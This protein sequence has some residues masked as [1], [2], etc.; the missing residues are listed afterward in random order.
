MAAMRLIRSGGRPFPFDC[1]WKARLKLWCW[2]RKG[3]RGIGTLR[4]EIAADAIPRFRFVVCL[5]TSPPIP[6]PLFAA[7]ANEGLY[8]SP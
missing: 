2:V 3:K 8:E 1:K 6:R 7:S 4:V 5:Q